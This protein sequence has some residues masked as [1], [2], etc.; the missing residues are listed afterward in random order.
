[1]DPTYITTAEWSVIS[2]I[3][4]FF[5]ATLLF[6]IGFA[7]NML[8]AHAFIPSLVGTGHL[9]KNAMAI[10]PVMYAVALASLGVAGYFFYRMV[11]LRDVFGVLYPTRWWM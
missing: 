10:R 5:F 7:G 6:V 3:L 11:T 4:R 1:M 8:L 9:P 2:Q